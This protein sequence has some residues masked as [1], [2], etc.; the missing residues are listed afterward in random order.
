MDNKLFRIDGGKV[1]LSQDARDWS[2]EWGMTDKE[3]ARY[4]I[5]RSRQG[6]EYDY[7]VMPEQEFL[8]TVQLG[9]ID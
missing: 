1:W 7:G 2:R 9:E 4:L 8:P 5:L 3:M 6:D